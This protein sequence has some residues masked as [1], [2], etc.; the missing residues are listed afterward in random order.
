MVAALGS[1][2]IS[3]NIKSSNLDFAVD[4]SQPIEL[5]NI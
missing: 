5:T 3:N 2:L 4:P 1:E